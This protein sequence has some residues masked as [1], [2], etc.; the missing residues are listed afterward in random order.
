M[1]TIIALTAKKDRS[2]LLINIDLIYFISWNGTCSIIY[3]RKDF[4]IEVVEDLNVIQTIIGRL[5]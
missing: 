1:A 5:S 3:F 2:K 4:W